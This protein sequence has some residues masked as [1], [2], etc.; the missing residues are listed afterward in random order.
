MNRK[1]LHNLPRAALC[2]GLAI[3]GGCA[4]STRNAFPRHY[5]LGTPATIASAPTGHAA[6]REAG[7]VLKI[8]GIDVPAWLAGTA[9]YYRLDYRDNQHVATYAQSDWI[10]PPNVMLE[11][12][13]RDALAAGGGWRAVLGP[14]DPATADVE[15]RLRVN[16]FSQVFSSPADST[17]VIDATATAIDAQNGR[18]LAQRHF[19]VRVRAPGAD[20]KGGARA[21]AE[22]ARQFATSLQ[23]WLA[24]LPRDQG[25]VPEQQHRS[26]C[27]YR[28]ETSRSRNTGNSAP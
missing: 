4:H 27:A 17:G 24:R 2:A 8:A 11:P 1:T 5:D 18:V 16:D 14:R 26:C 22:A 21:L 19:L 12:I 13:I 9:M 3:L 6:M 25:L 20:A 23:D 7:K 28:S 10:A 15:L